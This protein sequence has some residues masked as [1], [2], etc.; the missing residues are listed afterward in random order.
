MNPGNLQVFFEKYEDKNY[1]SIMKRFAISD[2]SQIDSL[3]GYFKYIMAGQLNFKDYNGT[4]EHNVFARLMLKAMK[5]STSVLTEQ[6]PFDLTSRY[7]AAYFEVNEKSCL[8]YIQ[9]AVTDID[10]QALICKN[11]PFSDLANV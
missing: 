7:M 9:K 4:Y 10:K 11:M 5:A 1:L 8:E 2:Q 6:L 3:I